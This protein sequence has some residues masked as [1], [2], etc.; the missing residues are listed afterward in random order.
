[1]AI[2]GD[3]AHHEHFRPAHAG[4]EQSARWVTALTLAMMAGEL[5]VGWWSGSLALL[6]DGWHMATHAGALGLAALAYWYAR[7]HASSGRYAFGTG[8]VYALSGFASAVALAIVALGMAGE[9]VHRLASPVPVQYR[10]A[11]VV[12]VIGLAVNLVSAWLLAGK[13][14]H[15]HDH[16]GHDHHGHD[17]HR[18]DHQGHDHGHHDQNMQAAYLHVLADAF[19]SVLAIVALLAG[20]R[21]GWAFLDPLMGVVGGAVILRWSWGLA[22]ST[23]ETLLDVVPDPTL[24]E[25][26][27]ARLLQFD[28]VRIVDLHVWDPGPDHRACIVSLVAGDPRPVDEYRAA[29]LDVTHVDHLTV[30]VH[31]R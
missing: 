23:A 14:D 22:R 3:P 16:H 10:E 30:E 9:G 29:I 21:L 26:I 28:G 17:H 12:A 8:K 7:E 27:R 6:A 20:S 15:G 24:G 19:T 4:R 18:H 5:A 13:H 1:M 25:R 2:A 11:L 31:G